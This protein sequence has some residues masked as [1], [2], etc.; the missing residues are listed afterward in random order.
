MLKT[1]IQ[2]YTAKIDKCNARLAEIDAALEE[3]DTQKA[4]AETRKSEKVIELKQYSEGK[5]LQKEKED[6]QKQI[7]NTTRMR[8]TVYKTM[9]KD[10]NASM[11]PFFSI[12]LIKRALEVLSRHDYSGKDIPFIRDKTIEYLLKQK[13]CLC[14][15]HLDEGCSSCGSAHRSIR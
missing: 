11:S 12:S 9:C 8:A 10:F 13:V 15:T 7:E 6:L 3:L 4:A 14:G 1:K 2:E 5:K